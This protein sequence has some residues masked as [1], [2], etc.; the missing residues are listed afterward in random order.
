MAEQGKLLNGHR[1]AEIL[2]EPAHGLGNLAPG[3]AESAQGAQKLAERTFQEPVVHLAHE[4][5]AHDG[6]LVGGAGEFHQADKGIKKLRGYFRDLCAADGTQA[7]ADGGRLRGKVGDE[8]RVD[9]QAHREIR[10]VF[11]GLRD[12]ADNGHIY[13]GHEAE[14]GAVHIFFVAHAQILLSL[15]NHDHAGTQKAGMARILFCI[16]IEDH[17]RHRS[18]HRPLMSLH[19]HID[20]IPQEFPGFV[21]IHAFCHALTSD[22]SK[23]ECPWH[24]SGEHLFHKNFFLSQRREKCA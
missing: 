24:P 2:P 4:Y 19:R 18:F 12:T 15:W 10:F 17:T 23:K 11:R 14:P 6:K 22:C 3:R 7:A 9:I 20:I 13:A 16:A 5:R 1:I 8:Y 21:H